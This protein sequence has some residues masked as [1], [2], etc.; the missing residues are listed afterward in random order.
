[1][2][3]AQ[4][5]N[6]INTLPKDRYA[7]FA[8]NP[9]SAI[10]ILLGCNPFPAS[11][12]IDSLLSNVWKTKFSNN[13]YKFLKSVHI[14]SVAMGLTSMKRSRENVLDGHPVKTKNSNT[15]IP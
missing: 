4:N 10:S 13:I 2:G 15:I 12:S 1:M 3:H 9:E 14:E 6:S 5:Q 7:L 8:R 11:K